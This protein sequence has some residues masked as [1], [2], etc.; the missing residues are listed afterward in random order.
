[1]AVPDV[2]GEDVD[3][4]DLV[5]HGALVER[6]GAEEAVDVPGAQVGDHLGRRRH[7]Q[8]DVAVRVQSML[9]QVVAQQE[10]V[11]RVLEGDRE[12][13]AL[14]VARVAVVLVLERERDRLPVDVLDGGHAHR[15]RRAALA[16]RHRQR[17]RRQEVRG[18]ELAVDHLV[19]HQ[20]PAGGLA[21]GDVQALRLVH[22]HRVGHDQGRG[23]V[24][25]D[26]AD[27]EVLL[28]ERARFFHRI[29]LQAGQRQQRTD[30]R[31]QRRPAHRLDQVA[32]RGVM[33]KQGAHRG[34]LDEVAGQRFGVAG[35]PQSGGLGL[36]IVLVLGAVLAARAAAQG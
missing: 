25:R 14:P 20:R 16:D 1:M 3:E 22:A 11:D 26:E 6:I 8:L 31:H 13:E 4:A 19:A 35:A 18:V 5:E 2:L 15:L 34:R 12:L 7:A 36:A 9:G 10:V 21:E 33:G 17:H 27:L 32:A 23:A 30:R 28:L 29:G 24:D